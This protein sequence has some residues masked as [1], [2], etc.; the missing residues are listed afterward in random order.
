MTPAEGAFLM[1]VPNLFMVKF[2]RFPAPPYDQLATSLL[3]LKQVVWSLVGAGGN[4]SSEDREEVI[5]VAKAF[6]NITG[7]VLD[8]FWQ[9]GKAAMSPEELGEVRQSTGKRLWGVLYTSEIHN[10]DA[11]RHHVPHMDHLT[12]WFWNPKKLDG[13]E[14]YVNALRGKC[15]HHPIHLGCYLWDFGGKRPMPH[16]SVERQCEFGL[17]SIKSGLVSGMVFIGTPVLDVGLESAE[18]VRNWVARVGDS[19]L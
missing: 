17:R 8:D 13:V 11:V 19:P 10:W 2:G 7:F 16:R 3:P 15:P 6:P 18:Y 9:N 14:H 12:L 5:R 1:G 4:T